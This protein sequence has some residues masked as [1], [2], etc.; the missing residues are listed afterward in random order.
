MPGHGAA[1]RRAQAT[2]L[3]AGIVNAMRCDRAPPFAARSAALRCPGRCAGSAMLFP[4]GGIAVRAVP[5]NARNRI[6][7][8][9]LYT[10]YPLT[11]DEGARPCACLCWVPAARAAT[12]AAGWPRRVSTSRFWCVE[13]M[14]N[15]LLCVLYSF[16]TTYCYT[17][18][19]RVVPWTAAELNKHI[20]DTAAP[21]TQ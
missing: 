21:S 14:V 12:L 17:S 10:A 8:V 4:R 19:G 3:A 2:Q 9:A 7:R 1:C 20:Q 15:V 13:Q 18:Q 16:Q 6:S 11:T 5:R